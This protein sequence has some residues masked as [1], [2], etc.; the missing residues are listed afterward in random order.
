[1]LAVQPAQHSLFEK[2]VSF[3]VIN[4]RVL[5]FMSSMTIETI[6]ASFCSFCISF[7][8]PPLSSCMV[9]SVHFIVDIRSETSFH[10]HIDRIAHY[11]PTATRVHPH[12]HTC[13][14][15]RSPAGEEFKDHPKPLQ[16]NN[17]MLCLTRPDVIIGIHTQYLEAGADFVETNTF[18]STRI[19]QA[20]YGT[21]HLVCCPDY[22]CRREY[23]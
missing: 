6:I 1:M 21:E 16:G 4:I 19:A 22:A 8:I 2:N 12:R 18:N 10:V 15:H 14:P 3:A 5:L 17:D 11:P 20:D 23:A 9:F 7:Q 13:P